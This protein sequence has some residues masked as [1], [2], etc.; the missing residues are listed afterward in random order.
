MDLPLDTVGN[1][2]TLFW[3]DPPQGGYNFGKTKKI[4]T[5]PLWPRTDGRILLRHLLR[6]LLRN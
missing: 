3:V 5:F 6:H 1:L 2:K 4:Q